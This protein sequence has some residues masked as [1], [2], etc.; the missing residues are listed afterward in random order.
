[1]SEKINKSEESTDGKCD[2]DDKG[3]KRKYAT[4]GKRVV[5]FVVDVMFISFFASLI[6]VPFVNSD[7]LSELEHD[8]FDYT[9]KYVNE[10]IS[11]K[12]YNVYQIDFNYNSARESGIV[13][14]VSILFSIIYFGVVQLKL[15]GQTLGKR[16]LRIRVKSD[17]GELTM[18]QLL[19]RSLIINSLLC[20][21]IVFAFMLFMNKNAYFYSSLILQTLQFIVMF[22]CFVMININKNNKGLH[23]VLFHTTVVNE[24]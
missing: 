17:N 22:I 11:P 15:G 4:F 9:K 23:D 5:A 24:E 18:N 10:E 21:I 16:M 19:F 13:E 12:E 7:N 1:M 2:K 8:Y 3:D 14:F 20:N 6:C